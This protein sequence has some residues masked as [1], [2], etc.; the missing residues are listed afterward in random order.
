MLEGM[1]DKN[2]NK[3][4]YFEI[5][6]IHMNRKNT[7]ALEI[8]QLVSLYFSHATHS[9]IQP[10]LFI[11]ATTIIKTTVPSYLEKYIHIYLVYIKPL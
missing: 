5:D 11:L 6:N 3:N 9:K 1:K 2:G 4:T 8:K 10:F 7:T